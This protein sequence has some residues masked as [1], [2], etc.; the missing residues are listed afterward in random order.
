MLKSLDLTGRVAVVAGGTSGIGRTLALGLAEAGADVI[1]FAEDFEAGLA[2]A[3]FESYGSLLAPVVNVVRFYEVL[4]VL[5]LGRVSQEMLDSV[6][7]NIEDCVLCPTL[8]AEVPARSLESHLQPLL[9]YALP[10]EAFCQDQRHFEALLTSAVSAEIRLLT[11]GEDITAGF[12]LK[13]LAEGLK[14]L[15]DYFPGR[16]DIGRSL[17]HPGAHD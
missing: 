5:L 10:S 13:R 8:T 16:P 9:A 2:Y 7:A 1:L 3:N 11:S 14:A 17:P 6:E 12:D 4:P 15:R